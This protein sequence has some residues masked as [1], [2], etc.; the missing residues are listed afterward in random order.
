MFFRLS[1]LLS[2][3]AIASVVSTQGVPEPAPKSPAPK[4]NTGTWASS[5]EM[6]LSFP[7]AN[8]NSLHLYSLITRLLLERP[9][10]LAPLSWALV[11][12]LHLQGGRIM[13]LLDAPPRVFWVLWLVELAQL[14]VNKEMICPIKKLKWFLNCLVGKLIS[15][16][17]WIPGP[18]TQS[19]VCCKNVYGVSRWCRL[20]CNYYSDWL[21]YIEW[22]PCHWLHQ[23]QCI[24]LTVHCHT[25]VP[26]VYVIFFNLLDGVNSSNLL[27]TFDTFLSRLITVL[28]MNL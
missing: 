4:C 18:C 6:V 20:T 19:P 21:H 7:A 2:I 23:P 16:L 1:T 8:D 27:Y 12:W 24:D 17:T 15:G 26:A 11:Y 13:S 3:I 14:T 25:Q 5:G 10:C 28:N 9:A 22:W